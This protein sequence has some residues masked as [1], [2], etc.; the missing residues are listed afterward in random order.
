METD[1]MTEQIPRNELQFVSR[2]H[3]QNGIEFENPVCYFKTN[4]QSKRDLAIRQIL[5]LFTIYPMTI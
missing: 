3:L 2:L 4:C 5:Q 1:Y